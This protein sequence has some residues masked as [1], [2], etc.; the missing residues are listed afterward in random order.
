MKIFPLAGTWWIKAPIP[1]IPTKGNPP[2]PPKLNTLR[3]MLDMRQSVVKN[4]SQ[5]NSTHP[6]VPSLFWKSPTKL[7]AVS[8]I[9]SEQR[10]DPNKVLPGVYPL[11]R[12]A[13]ATRNE[14]AEL[15]RAPGKFFLKLASKADAD[16]AALAGDT[17]PREGETAAIIEEMGAMIRALRVASSTT[18][19]SAAALKTWLCLVVDGAKAAA[20]KAK[21]A[22]RRNEKALFRPIIVIDVIRVV[23][24]IQELRE[25]FA[26]EE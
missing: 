4:N 26:M 14:M 15:V 10:L 25:D 24:L 5:L 8:L 18:W 21:L 16:G 2:N 20:S 11:S 1:E 9:S 12:S 6:S 17:R 19:S 13:A 3:K 23:Q 22:H 7:S